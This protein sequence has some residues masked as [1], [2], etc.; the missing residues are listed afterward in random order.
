[1]RDPYSVLGVSKNASE[2]EI[3][4][5]FRKSAKKY[6]PDKNPN[7]PKAREQFTQ[8][9]TAYEILSDNKKR[10][11]FD[12]GQID[13]DGKPKASSGRDPFSGFRAGGTRQGDFNQHQQHGFSG[14]EDILKE[15][16]GGGFAGLNPQAGRTQSAPSTVLAFDVFVTL[17]EVYRCEKIDARLPDGRILAVT[18]PQAVSNG[19]QIR[20]KGQGHQHMGGRSDAIATVR[21]RNHLDY[22]LDD[23]DLH[24]DL[25][26][27]LKDAV[28]GAK[29]PVQTLSG[30]LVLTIPLWSSSDKVLRLKNKG[31]PKKDGSFGDL[32]VHIRIMLPQEPD[33][34]L[35]NYV[36]SLN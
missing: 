6:H 29:M 7:D 35:L 24:V 4:S 33:L 36:R 21:F 11:Q 3:K 10:N 1:M 28:L 27:S 23:Y 20:L 5:A 16:F 17:E 9:N 34:G 8:A 14:A 31:M 15:M 18:L 30:K 2:Q 22:R 13:G 26:V 32:L 19:Q 12:A 25:P